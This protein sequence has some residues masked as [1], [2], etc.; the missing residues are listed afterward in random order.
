MTFTIVWKEGFRGVRA[1]T[2]SASDCLCLLLVI[3]IGAQYVKES[4]SGLD[5]GLS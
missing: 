3:A 1:D 2:M 5:R 4:V